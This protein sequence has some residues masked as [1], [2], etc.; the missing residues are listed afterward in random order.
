[1]LD[2]WQ[3]IREIKTEWSDTYEIMGKDI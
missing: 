2:N 3:L 1:M